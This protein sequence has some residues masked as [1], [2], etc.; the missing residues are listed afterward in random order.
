MVLTAKYF[1]IIMSIILTLNLVIFVC[2][3][4]SLVNFLWLAIGLTSTIVF[5]V[6]IIIQNSFE[7]DSISLDGKDLEIIEKHLKN[8]SISPSGKQKTSKI[9]NP[10]QSLKN[11]LISIEKSND[12]IVKELQKNI[13]SFLEE[14]R[15]EIET[16]SEQFQES[17][18][19]DE[20]QNLITTYQHSFT[21]KIEDEFANNYGRLK[22]SIDEVQ[23][24]IPEIND[25]INQ[26]IDQKFQIITENL[27][28][29]FSELLNNLHPIT[30][31]PQQPDSPNY[32]SNKPAP[33]EE[34]KTTEPLSPTE[35]PESP[36]EQITDL[37]EHS[38]QDGNLPSNTNDPRDEE[39]DLGSGSKIKETPPEVEV[40][41]IKGIQP[42]PSD[43]N[44]EDTVTI[45]PSIELIGRTVYT[46][47]AEELSSQI[48][49]ED[50]IYKIQRNMHVKDL[51][52][53]E[54]LAPRI[55]KLFKNKEIIIVWSEKDPEYYIYYKI[56]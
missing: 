32:P 37:G 43:T 36:I 33:L 30:V 55:K 31:L 41:G 7:D 39:I 11:S 14:I 50:C 21:T 56:K 25:V 4:Y 23:N 1:R 27:E 19:L 48:F 5:A 13:L 9:G 22:S 35:T 15:Q 49:F 28:S 10:K 20:I 24:A 38:K 16:T 17:I 18:F 53:F 12:Q 45:P 2:L 44:G 47:E 46:A 40:D 42:S 3:F 54:E 52:D 8:V 51:K 26:T 6:I 34:E 29:R